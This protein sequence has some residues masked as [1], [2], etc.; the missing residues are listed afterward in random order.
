[1]S[2]KISVIIPTYKRPQLLIKCL[3]ALKKQTFSAVDFEVI[4]VSDGPDDLTKTEVAYFVY[5][6][7]MQNLFFTSLDQKAGPAAARNKG[8]NLAKGDLI[9]FTDDD[10]IPGN[11]W[12]KAWWDE[13]SKV[14]KTEIAFTGKT[15]VPH[16]ERPTDYEKNIA[17][18]ETAEFITAN[19]ACTKQAFKKVGGFDE[20]FP[21]AWREDSDLHFKFI[22]GAIPIIKVE[23]AVIV[24]PVRQAPW[25]VSLKEQKKSKYN[26]L[27]R[28]KHPL[29]YKEKIGTKPLWNYY[30]IVI[31]LPVAIAGYYNQK[32]L[33]TIISGSC[34]LLLVTQ[35]VIKRLKGT[36]KKTSH[37]IEMIATSFIIPFLSVFWTLY[38]SFRYKKF[39]L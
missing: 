31:L 3:N 21:I 39:L 25:G 32:P 2:I 17:N 33:I 8:A 14:Q 11:S 34:C 28:K 26:A 1:M 35:F 4:V 12:L 19:C 24:H 13:F 27:L 29:L 6:H 9:A 23:N 18:L 22:A 15:I 7:P 5:Q 30:A 36:S 20:D 38:G 37:I 16:N 10:C